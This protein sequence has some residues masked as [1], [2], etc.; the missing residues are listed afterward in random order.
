MIIESAFDRI[1]RILVLSIGIGSLVFSALA[2]PSMVQQ[3]P[4]LELGYS[5]I[6]IGIYCG[7]PLVLGALAFRLPVRTLRVGALLH[8]LVSLVLLAAW[9]PSMV[10]DRLPGDHIPWL[11]NIITAA[12][13]MMGLAVRPALAWLYLVIVAAESGVV[14]Y[15]A[16]GG[17]DATLA[18][19]DSIM[20]TLISGVMLSLLLLAARA[21]VE[22][23]AVAVAAQDAAAHVATVQ[24]LESQRARFQA[25][26]HDD[27]LATLHTASRGG[28]TGDDLSRRSAAHALQKMDEFRDGRSARADFTLVE[29][30]ALLGTAAATSGI[31]LE[32]VI[33]P[34]AADLAVPVDTGD[35]L[36]EALAEALR[37]SVRHADWPDSR[38][39]RRHALATLTAARVDIV[40]S[41]DGKGFVARR[42]GLDRL[43]IR[44]SILKRVNAQ[45]G[46]FA[47]V[48][49]SKGRG[50]T[51]T[52]TWTAGVHREH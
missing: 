18:I 22:Q 29:F 2:L 28:A 31:E 51:V 5:I 33:G 11:I 47:S 52:L 21:G 39:V 10:S 44:V 25:F 19:Q 4:H 27:V 20:I 45:P 23:D 41:D 15:L 6:T 24:V 50:T 14:R 9:V 17:G 36:A 42:I 30:E 38:P 43:G 32:I 40:V 7:M 26:M 1:F 46:G 8:A 37:N 49:S 12:I 16:Y 13:C 34:D 35:A 48:R 3:L